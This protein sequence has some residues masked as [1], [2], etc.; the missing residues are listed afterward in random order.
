MI[1]GVVFSEVNTVILSA[2]YSC[3]MLLMMEMK[4]SLQKVLGFQMVLEGLRNVWQI[5]VKSYLFAAQPCCWQGFF[6]MKRPCE[7]ISRQPEQPALHAAPPNP[8]SNSRHSSN[9]KLYSLILSYKDLIVC[10][11]TQRIQPPVFF[12][13]AVY[14]YA[15][16]IWN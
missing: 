14:C 6:Y 3:C 1:H 9:C 8:L 12:L 16:A 11:I 7:R 5:L 4:Y 13:L 10:Y 15:V 2:K